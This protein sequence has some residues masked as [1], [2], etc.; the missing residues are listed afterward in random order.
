ME[1]NNSDLFDGKYTNFIYIYIYIYVRLHFILSLIMYVCNENNRILSFSK[2][3]CFF[4]INVTEQY[5]NV[6]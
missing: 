1:I 3:N 6:Y 2:K 5:Q 4:S